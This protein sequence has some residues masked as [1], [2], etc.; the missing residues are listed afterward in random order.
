MLAEMGDQTFEIGHV[1]NATYRSLI[2]SDKLIELISSS[3]SQ[4]APECV[5]CVLRF[6]LW[7]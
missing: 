4:C 2:L 6:P 7:C 3:L 5:D 1:S